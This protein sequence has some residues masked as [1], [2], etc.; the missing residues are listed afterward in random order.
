M[1]E[2]QNDYVNTTK[3]GFE[4]IHEITDI[5]PKTSFTPINLE[6]EV[7]CPCD[8]TKF[9]VNVNKN[10]EDWRGNGTLDAFFNM[11]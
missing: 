6:V 3:E 9:M 8:G 1:I 11:V 2:F 4:Y 5:K 10:V 7:E